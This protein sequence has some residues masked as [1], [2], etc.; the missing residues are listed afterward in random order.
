[1]T[2]TQTEGATPEAAPE[3]APVTAP[4][5][6]AVNESVSK[7]EAALEKEREARKAAD[8]RAKENDAYRSKV[9][10]LESAN[11]SE[12]ERAVDAARKEGESSAL[13]RANARLVSAEARAIA[14]G[15]QFRD[16]TDAV[17]FL[18]L[19]DVSVSEDGSVD[20]DALS[21][22][23]EQLAK[24]KPY[25]LK[26]NAPTRP[27]GDVGQ[28]PRTPAAPEIQPGMSRIRAAYATKP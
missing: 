14:A 16:A 20:A 9:E 18:D 25:L 8:K 3:K 23:L 1:M 26:D 17:R 2:E 24:D 11:K 22:Q 6:D 4:V 21:K 10:Q 5:A 19:S 13:Q 27:T 28:G 12:L 7:L 15:Q